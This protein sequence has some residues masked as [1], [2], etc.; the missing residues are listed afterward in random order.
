[1]KTFQSSFCPAFLIALSLIL[2]SAVFAQKDTL[3]TALTEKSS[4]EQ[5]LNWLDKAS[6][7][8]ARIGL[9]ANVKEPEAGEVITTATRYYEQAFFSKGFRLDKIDGCR[10]KLK[11]DDVELL[12]YMSGYPDPSKGSLRFKKTQNDQFTGE[13]FIPLQNLKAN[14]APYQYTKK[15]ETADLLG[16]WRTEFKLKSNLSFFSLFPVIWS[17]EKAQE[18]IEELRENAMRVEIIN[19][20]PNEQNDL[21]YGDE[22]TFTFDDKQ[23]S[24][25]FY[26]AFS[27]A[28][29]LCKDR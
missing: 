26:A 22:L 10:V 16:T 28:I 8:Q 2:N 12:R 1:M 6:L 4:L 25:N 27:R 20:K 23:A 18:K 29:A 24:E 13:F 11:N 15:A 21:M 5:I 9:E 14:K 7:P 19:S 17:K 3:P